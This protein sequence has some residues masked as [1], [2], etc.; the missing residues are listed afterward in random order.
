MEQAARGSSPPDLRVQYLHQIQANH[1]VSP[2]SP[3]SPRLAPGPCRSHPALPLPRPACPEAAVPLRGQRKDLPGPPLTSS[4]GFVS[5]L[6]RAGGG[7]GPSC[8]APPQALL[9]E[10]QALRDRLCTEDEASSQATA[11]RLLQVYQQL[12]SPRLLLL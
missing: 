8:C 11:E 7:W 5:D 10:V 1:E 2:P 3:V 9:R 4:V 12:R 6:G